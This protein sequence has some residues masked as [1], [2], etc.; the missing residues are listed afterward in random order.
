M[1]TVFNIAT[2]FP[3][4]FLLFLTLFLPVFTTHALLPIFQEEVWALGWMPIRVDGQIRFETDGY[5]WTW[6]FSNLDINVADSLIPGYVWR[7]TGWTIGWLAFQWAVAKWY[8]SIWPSPTKSLSVSGASVQ[9]VQMILTLKCGQK[10]WRQL[11][12]E[13]QCDELL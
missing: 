11:F 2:S 3:G 1:N 8:S 12:S 5:V 10:G 7:G 13:T 4:F 6:E 9:S